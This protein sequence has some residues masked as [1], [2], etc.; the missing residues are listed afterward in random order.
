MN[1]FKM[2]TK[3]GDW[4]TEGI[5]KCDC[6]V[7]NKTMI[8]WFNK[9]KWNPTCPNG[10]IDEVHVF[11]DANDILIG[12]YVSYFTNVTPQELYGKCF[13]NNNLE[14]LGLY[15]NASLQDFRTLLANNTSGTQLNNLSGIIFNVKK[16]AV[17]ISYNTIPEKKPNSVPVYDQY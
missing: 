3:C 12:K 6:N 11:N 2:R 17:N 13:R 1:V 8:Y 10:P 9:D 15:P 16:V 5:N 4:F 7:T 14:A